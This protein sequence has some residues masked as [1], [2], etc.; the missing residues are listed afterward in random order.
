[1]IIDDNM[2]VWHSP[3]RKIA[4]R[5]ELYNNFTL[6][7][8]FTPG[9]A[10]KSFD[11]ERVGGEGKFFGFGISQ[12]VELKLVDKNRAINIEKG[13][14]LK[15]Y[16]GTD[17]NY[18]IN[19][20]TTFYVE[21][22]D[23]D[24]NT[25]ELKII[26]YDAIYDLSNYTY[27]DILPDVN[28]E[29]YNLTYSISG[30][31]TLITMHFITKKDMKIVN[32]TMPEG[33]TSFYLSGQPNCE[34]SETLRE[35]LDA[36]A[37]ATQTIYYI[38][39]NK[40]LVFKA[41]DKEGAANLVIGKDI[42]MELDSKTSRTITSVVSATELGDNVGTNA[43]EGETQYVRDNP[44][45][46]LHEDIAA[47]VDAAVEKVS[48]LTIA[49]FDCT[50]RGDG[51]LEP[52]DK[53]SIVAK[54][55]SYITS[56]LINDTISYSGGLSQKTYWSFEGGESAHTNPT[57]LGGALK[58]TYAKVDKANK[59]IEIVAGETAAI[60]LTTETV[61]TSVSKMD[62]D[63]TGVITEVNTKVTAEDVS[64]SIQ[65]AMGEGVERVTT[66]TGFTFN[67]EGLHINKENSEITTSIT[68]DGMT[69]YREDDEVL[70]ANNLGVKAEDL[71]ATTFLIIGNNSRL[72]DYGSR[73]GCF[74]IGK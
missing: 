56:Y 38:N 51:R 4:A 35:L 49:Q 53:I 37:E 44:F 68:E 55:D 70:V 54:D 20:F 66:T 74:W 57:T 15:C 58:K 29:D 39:N 47:L 62:E 40:T 5:V 69:V 17:E 3:R 36:I 19:P 71:H 64:Y 12:K 45:W 23:R 11:V 26:A 46:E 67:E 43:A 30:I 14:S 22:V 7:N 60:K 27:N 13:Y 33:D 16:L 73:T 41:L 1:M 24:E 32:F 50:W 28:S 61:Q 25:N 59:E 65:T 21:E 6:V 52:G 9:D 48:G 31:L 63:M 72:E 10:L 2:N 34:G 8:T 42:Y 18:L